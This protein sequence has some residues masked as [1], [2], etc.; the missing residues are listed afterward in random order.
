MFKQNG[1]Y[2]ELLSTLI[3]RISYNKCRVWKALHLLK[4]D[5]KNDVEDW[6]LGKFV[7]I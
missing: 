7:D 2:V 6:Y 4:K 5:V 3:Y 1:N